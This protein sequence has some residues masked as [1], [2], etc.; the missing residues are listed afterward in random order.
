MP[1]SPLAAVVAAQVTTGT[2]LFPP[3]DVTAEL[4]AAA[5]A[6]IAHYPSNKRSATLPLLH[7]VQHK[8]G[9]IS[10]AA[11]QWVA[12]K[13]GLEPIQ[14]L[15]VVTFYPGFRQSAPGK[16]QFI[17]RFLASANPPIPSSKALTGSGAGV[18]I[19]ILPLMP[20]PPPIVALPFVLIP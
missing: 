14:V 10:A 15:E 13:L 3:F 4:D 9:Y 19:T 18:G 6:S 2:A 20:P 8:F 5:D 7:L 1:H 17:F 12:A 11:I 16:T